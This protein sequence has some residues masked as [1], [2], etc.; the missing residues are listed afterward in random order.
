LSLGSALYA[1]RLE[2]TMTMM[3]FTSYDFDYHNLHV[4]LFVNAVYVRIA[5]RMLRYAAIFRY[6]ERAL[7]L[8]L[9][10]RLWDLVLRR[11]RLRSASTRRR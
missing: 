5:S 11:R 7:D 2:R 3:T 8:R 10:R 9:R 4:V 6:I 1:A